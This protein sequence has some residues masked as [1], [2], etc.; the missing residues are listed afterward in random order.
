M[1]QKGISQE[2]IRTGRAVDAMEDDPVV[3]RIHYRR[4]YRTRIITT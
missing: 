1:L 4:L 2:I 3:L